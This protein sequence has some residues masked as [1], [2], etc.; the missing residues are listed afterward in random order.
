[1]FLY[2]ILVERRRDCRSA[3]NDVE[4]RPYFRW[5]IT[6][7]GVL[8]SRIKYSLYTLSEVA[9]LIIAKYQLS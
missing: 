3:E 6:I 5:G 2:Q 8:Q 7:R 1:M 4:I 9:I